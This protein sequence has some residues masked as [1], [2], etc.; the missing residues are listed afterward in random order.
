I[1]PKRANAL[2]LTGRQITSREALALGVVNE[3]VADD[4]VMGAARRW[5]DEIML[6]SPNSVAATKAIANRLDG[7][8]V[9]QSMT[10]MLTLP[11]VLGMF[12]SPNS[13]EGPKAF[14]ERRPPQWSNPA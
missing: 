9:E 10:S 12:T 5:A 6:C 8:T 1:G 14:A 11:E 3:V 13:R 2:L 7:Q 4:E